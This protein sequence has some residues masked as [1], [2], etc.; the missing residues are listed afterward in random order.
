MADERT[1]I[2]YIGKE[3]YY[4]DRIFGTCSPRSRG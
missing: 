3:P 2:K 1:G 4:K